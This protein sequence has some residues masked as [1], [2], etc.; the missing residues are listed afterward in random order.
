MLGVMVETWIGWLYLLLGPFT[1]AMFAFVMIKGR[2]RME[3]LVRPA[4]PIPQPPPSI[5]VLIPAKDEAGQIEK[6]VNSVLK[7]D[8]SNFSVIVIDDRSTDG[9]GKILDDMAAKDSRLKIVHL[10]EGSLPPGWGGK[11]FA[12]HSGLI[13]AKGE[14][15]LFVDADVLLEPD[16]M[17]ATIAW[18]T[19]R[20]FDLISLLPKFV[21]G[22]VAEGWLQPLAGAATSAMF[23][24]ALTNSNEWPRT[25]FANGQYLMVRR[26]AYEAVG[27]HEAIR[28][29]LSEDVA[30]ARKLK[31]AGYRPRLGWGDSWATVR[32][33]EGFG[34]IFRGWSRNF[35]VGS[36]GKPWRI[37]GLI[38][39]I[40]LCC[41]SVFAAWGWAAFRFA[42]PV[43]QFAG[44]GWLG[45]GILHY[46]LMTATAGLM[47]LWAGEPVWYAMLFPF[48]VAFLL[49]V[50]AKSLWIC[51]T[52]KVVW[53]GTQYSRERL[54][55]PANAQ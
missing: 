13:E 52:G 30:I 6:C 10:Q 24:I 46:V 20:K 29:T 49:A 48:G 33:Y 51:M 36:L 1:W 8:Y 7:Q 12:L 37:L 21:S 9:T 4:P 39:F 2:R 3:I 26:D 5:S 22:T 16:V 35:Y 15:L 42:H 38:A 25:A 32:M 14:W 31:I 23:V 43:D 45:A 19:R 28:G 53:R 17:G 40:F 18:A 47:Y 41:Y 11:S 34:A 54:E 27:G 44:W 55:E 50:S